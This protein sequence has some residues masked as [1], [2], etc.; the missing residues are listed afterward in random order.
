MDQHLFFAEQYLLQAFLAFNPNYEVLFAAQ[1]LSR[2]HR[3]AVSTPVP[4]ARDNLLP[5]GPSSFWIRHL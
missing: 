4:S 2:E 1:A 3:E 5:V